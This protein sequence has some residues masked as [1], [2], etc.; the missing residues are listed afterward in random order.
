[1]IDAPASKR[2]AGPGGESG[3]PRGRRTGQHRGTILHP[4]T[5]L[6]LVCLDAPLVAVSWQWLFAR[7][8]DV[9]VPTGASAALFLTAWLI[10]LADRFG[11]S[12]SIDRQHATSLRQRF[13]LKHRR[14]WIVAVAL[15]AAADLLVVSTTVAMRVVVLA[16]PVAAI[17][18]TYLIL[19]QR[20]QALWRILPV[21]EITIGGLFA[22]GTMVALVP[23]LDA[24]ATLPWL[25][26]AALCS[27]NC[28]SI[29]VWERWLDQAQSRVSIATAFPQVGSLVLPVL[30]SLGVCS[31]AAARN[32]GLGQS[33]F[34]C[35]SI[36]ATLLAVVHLLRRRVQADVRT[37]LADLVLLS[38]LLAIP[39]WR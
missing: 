9:S 37:A 34:V 20:C 6:N 28:I 2:F 7:S 18:I 25:M 3:G 22:A 19:N 8:L 27:L 32:A 16:A 4:L 29:A 17:A 39:L 13:C 24:S 15:V 38:P 35:I 31:G 26:F 21:K 1:M 30:V 14:A 33:I 10:Y 11:D 12:L 23:Q 5:W 36:S